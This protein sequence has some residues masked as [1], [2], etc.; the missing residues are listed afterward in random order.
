MT[1]SLAAPFISL[2]NA[3]CLDVLPAIPDGAVD[4]IVA[5]LPYSCTSALWDDGIDLA[6]VWAEFRRVLSANGSVVMFGRQPFATRMAAPALDLLKY[7]LVWE[8]PKATQHF[9]A[10]NRPLAAHEDILV[11][12]KGTC[13]HAARSKRRMTYH[14]VGA[15]AGTRRTLKL[16][17]SNIY[18]VFDGTRVGEEY[19]GMTGAPR[20]VLR[21]G[22]DA[23]STHES[24][25]PVALI[26][27]LIAA[28]SNLGDLVLDPTMG[29]GTTGVAAIR[30][31][32]DF[33]G[34]ER[35]EPFYDQASQRISDVTSAHRIAA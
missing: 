35:D 2:V 21:C 14:P 29:S 32:R 20:S 13:I 25:K 9:H 8:K 17:T 4:L 7:G 18:R 26:E 23:G 22:K 1:A 33:I 15:G 6:A 34:I 16:A 28:Y 12:S 19:D 10:R 27:W 11:F 24:Q 5:D 31:A 3:D 30:T